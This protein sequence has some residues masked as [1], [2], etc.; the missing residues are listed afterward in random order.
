VAKPDVVVASYEALVS[1]AASLKALPWD[2]IAVDARTRL[3]SALSRTYQALSPFDSRARAIL[4]N[5]SLLHSVCFHLHGATVA[6]HLII[7][8]CSEA[9][10]VDATE[11]S[12]HGT[13]HAGELEAGH[14]VPGRCARYK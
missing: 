3:H 14:A 13:G 12:A 10:G 7:V 2:L 8:P 9:S 11:L 5:P 1:D 6:C 4:A